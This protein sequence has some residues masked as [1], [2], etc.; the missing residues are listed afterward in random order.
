MAVARNIESEIYLPMG[1]ENDRQKELI[2]SRRC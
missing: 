1:N 2:Y